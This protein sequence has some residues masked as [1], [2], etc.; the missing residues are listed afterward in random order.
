MTGASVNAPPTH[1]AAP[2]TVDW[3]GW[4]SA[5][6]QFAAA[7]GLVVSA[8]DA[9]GKRRLGPFL[10]S[11]LARTLA[12][13]PLW[14]AD[15]PGTTLERQLA[16]S[17][18]GSMQAE[19]IAFCEQLC[20]HAVP[21]SQSGETY[22]AVVF[23][24]TFSTFASAMGCE[25]IAKSLGLPGAKLWTEA[26]LESPVSDARM[27]TYSDLLTTLITANA[28][29]AEAIE[30]LN[31][32]S[33]LRE[34]FLASVSHEMRTPLAAISLRLELLLLSKLNDPVALRNALTVMK[35]HVDQEAKLV[36]DMI[37]AAR[38][39]T[40][41]LSI[42]PSEVSLARVMQDALSTVT[43]KAESKGISIHMHAPDADEEIPVW[44]D[45]QRLQQL[46]W[47]LLFNA[48]KFTPPGGS[49][50]VSIKPSPHLHEIEV[51]DT[52][53]GIAAEFIPHVFGAFNKQQRDN[54]QGL[55]L[56]LFIAKHIVDLHGGSIR[57]AS[58]GIDM[59][60]VFT[61]LLPGRRANA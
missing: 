46:F 22:G 7:T 56:G 30:R 61:V 33:R 43:L 16:E 48:V 52:G 5:L 21:L 11:R 59:G 49:I 37:E 51:R 10:S 39:R 50:H 18:M 40:G 17:S 15:G 23:G 3:E 13:S 57:V 28:R 6:R 35:A 47:N 2:F 60:T 45:A 32:L 26:R 36:E 42:T 25:C 24:W 27:Q 9:Q 8:Y 53:R 34:V 29:Q 41:Q 4:D 58:P 44:G 31:A 1:P 38:T 55:G 20:V 54:E 19:R 14:D 12:T